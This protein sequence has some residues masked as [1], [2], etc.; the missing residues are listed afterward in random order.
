[1]CNVPGA[2]EFDEIE[3]QAARTGNHLRAAVRMS[4][5]ARKTPAAD[6]TAAADGGATGISRAEAHMRAGD[7]WLMADEPERAVDEFNQALADG[8]PTFAD[9]RV[10]LARAYFAL[11]KDAEAE[12]LIAA[13]RAEQQDVTPRTCDL[14]AELL[15]DQ[16]DLNGALEWA[17][18]GVELYL[19][20][21]E[22]GELRLLLRLRYR[23]RN[24]LGL[25]EDDYD[26]M[27]DSGSPA[28]RGGRGPQVER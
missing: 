17:T 13:L 10:P 11:G 7:Q 15:A 24:D 6:E 16:G 1:M 22:N 25:D 21:G 20:R 2:E 14:L 12:S 28:A 4:D 23:I 26:R 8:G 27:L 18:R 9:P 19:R 3:F 5:L